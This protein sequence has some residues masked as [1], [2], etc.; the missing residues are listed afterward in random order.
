M[1]TKVGWLC[2]AVAAGAL[3]ASTVAQAQSARLGFFPRSSAATGFVV[4]TRTNAVSVATVNTGGNGWGV[5]VHPLGHRAYVP[6]QASNT[7]AVINTATNAIVATVTVGNAPYHAAVSPDGSE[8]WVPN[9]GSGSVSIISSA[10]NTVVATITGLTSAN[11]VAFHPNGSRAYVSGYS[12]GQLY[13]INTATRTLVA[14]PAIGAGSEGLAVHP[15]GRWVYSTSATGASGTVSV[16]DTTTNTVTQSQNIGTPTWGVAVNPNGRYYYV[17]RGNNS[18]EVMDVATNQR[19]STIS[20]GSGNRGPTGVNITPNGKLAYVANR[21]NN[22]VAVVN[23]VTHALIQDITTNVSGAPYALGNAFAQPLS[24]QGRMT[25][26]QNHT[27]RLRADN[28]VDCWGR[29]DFGQATAPTGQFSQ[30]AGGSAHSC[31]LRTDGTLTCWGNNSYTQATAPSGTYTQLTSGA[32]HNCAI[33]TSDRALVCWGENTVGQAPALTTG[34]FQDVS[35]GSSHTCAVRQTGAVAC[36]GNNA[37]GQATAPSGTNFVQ[38]VAG[39]SFTCT[40]NTAG[41]VACFGDPADGRTTAPSGTF[42]RLYAQSGYACAV[43]DEGAPTCWGADSYGETTLP[44]GSF[45]DLAPG[46]F[47]GCGQRALGVVQCW[48]WNLYNQAPQFELLPATVPA[49]GTVGQVFPTTT[50][51]MSVSNPGTRYPYVPRTPAYARIAG[52]LPPGLSLGAGG[53]LSGTPTTAGTYAFTVEAEDANGFTASRAYS[54]TIGSTDP[55]PPVITPTVTGKAGNNG[56]FRGP[57]TVTWSVTDPQSNISSM[58]GCD[59]V[60]ISAETAGTTVTCSATSAGGVASQ[61]VLVRIDFTP[62]VLAPTASSTRPVLNQPVL[63]APNGSDALSGLAS[64][65]CEPSPTDSVS[66]AM[67]RVNC[68]A[69]DVAGNSVTRAAAYR[70]IFGFEGFFDTVANPGWFNRVAPGQVLTFKYR[71]TDVNAVP[72]TNLSSVGVTVT[73]VACGN[74]RMD[75]PVATASPGL[76]HT[77]NGNYEFTWVAP[78]TPGCYRATLDLGDGDHV[79]WANFKVE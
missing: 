25:A 63:V 4:D 43:S 19:L 28:T 30:L 29:N 41:A 24:G 46:R 35:A 60:V 45:A 7:V 73:S 2:A 68:T 75:T 8:V 31:G 54:I 12:N 58:T 74:V 71:V 42:S 77:G 47:H 37:S 21:T 9:Y 64:Q 13:V 39:A 49:T 15:T 48:G 70:V 72:Q 14:N 18:L 66:F 17:A 50:I 20:L 61:G 53:V 51:Q 79:R 78:A 33:R 27:C 6:H 3:V 34:P 26:G 67:K 59:P 44:S 11:A 10:T 23:L 62:P 69:T 32:R 36:W 38:V 5:A 52:T 40:L 22:T 76:V 65:T 55:S 57:V 16:L 56:W 1:N